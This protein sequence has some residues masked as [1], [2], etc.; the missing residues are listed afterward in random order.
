MNITTKILHS[1]PVDELTGSI[2]V[3]I[4][5]TSPLSGKVQMALIGLSD[6]KAWKRTRLELEEITWAE[7][8][9]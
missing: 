2:A 4:Y 1:I 7:A 8:N 6:N 9:D 5:Q 3:P